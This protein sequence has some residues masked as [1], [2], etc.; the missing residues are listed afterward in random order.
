MT[1]TTRATGHFTAA[2]WKEH[3]VTPADASPRLARATVTNTFTGGI[4]AA[5]TDCAYAVVYVPGGTGTFAGIELFSGRLDGRVGAFAVEE[6]GSFGADGTVRCVFEVV[7][8]SG[9]GELAG[10]RGTGEFTARHGEERVAY[11][12]AYTLG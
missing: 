2:G 11:T 5:G 3:P 7:A 8:G 1:G 4:E 12:F 10:L 6:R 9:T